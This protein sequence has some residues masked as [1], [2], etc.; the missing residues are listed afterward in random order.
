M[1]QII[2]ILAENNLQRKPEQTEECENTITT[3]FQ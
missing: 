3:Y 2:I 1:K